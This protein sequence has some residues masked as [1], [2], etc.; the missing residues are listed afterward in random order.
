MSDMPCIHSIA[1]TSASHSTFQPRLP[2]VSLDSICSSN[3]SSIDSFSR[4]RYP[5]GVNHLRLATNNAHPYEASRQALLLCSAPTPRHRAGEGHKL[6]FS[7]P[8]SRSSS[9]SSATSASSSSVHSIVGSAASGASYHNCHGRA[10]SCESSSSSSS[11]SSSLSA[12][13]CSDVFPIKPL[14]SLPLTTDSNG[15]KTAASPQESTTSTIIST[16]ITRMPN[17]QSSD[18]IIGVRHKFSQFWA[19]EISD[20]EILTTKNNDRQLCIPDSSAKHWGPIPSCQSLSATAGHENFACKFNL[21]C[22]LS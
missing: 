19:T 18:H 10:S 3:C 7:L 12:S 14:K 20:Q 2:R 15:L 21:Y 9:A 6:S 1:S 5:P 22:Y 4:P 11:S 8:C 16:S 13:E 17:P